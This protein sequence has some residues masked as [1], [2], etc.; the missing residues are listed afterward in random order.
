MKQDLRQQLALANQ[1][2]HYKSLLGL[3]LEL[4]PI[5]AKVEQL[6]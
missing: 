3:Q 5:C 1:F 2:V 4:E 6:C